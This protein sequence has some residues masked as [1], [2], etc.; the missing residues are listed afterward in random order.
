VP[1]VALA[2]AVTALVACALPG[3]GMFVAI[4]AGIAG[5]GLGRIGARRRQA[6]G[7]RRLLAATAAAIAGLALVLA[8]ARYALTLVALSRLVELLG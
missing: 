2:C 8:L 1:L 3:A 4:G 7:A 5:V 6:P